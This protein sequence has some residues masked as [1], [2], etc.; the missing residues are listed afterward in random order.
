[1]SEHFLE[2]ETVRIEFPDGNWVAIKEEL[3][4]ADQD[5]IMNQMVRAKAGKE[6]TTKIES[7]HLSLLERSIVDWRFVGKDGSK[8]PV[9]R[10]NI[11]SLRLRY[12]TKVL[13]EINHLNEQAMEF[14]KKN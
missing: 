7:G 3:T 8:V 4:Q 12:R 1:M 6:T 10:E 9:T 2:S 11:S 13:V 5:Y 14:A